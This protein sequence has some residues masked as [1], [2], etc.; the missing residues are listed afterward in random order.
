MKINEAAEYHETLNPRIWTE[1]N[2]LRPEVSVALKKIVNFFVEQSE[3]NIPVLD[4]YL[5]GSNASYNYSSHSDLDVHIITNYEDVD[6]N[7][8]IVQLLYNMLKT[9]FNSD[10]EFSVHGVPVELYV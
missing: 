4:V 3:I 8:E 6:C 10:Y 7:E 2:Q 5:V 9:K 1:D